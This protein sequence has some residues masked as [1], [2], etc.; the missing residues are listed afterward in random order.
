MIKQN[1]K[2]TYVLD[3]NILMV[4]PKALFGFK[5][6]NVV[7]TGTTLQE[8]DHH[9]NDVGERGFNTRETIR[10]LDDLR[11]KGNLLKG[12]E[13]FSGGRLILEPN[14]I[15]KNLPQ[16][17]SLDVP[18]NRIISSV[19]GMAESNKYDKP[20]ILVTND[21][22][23]R[24]NAS[25]CGVTVQGYR[26]EM[27]EDNEVYKGKREYPI[28]DS[29][30][31]KLYELKKIKASDKANFIENEYVVLKSKKNPQK[32]A[33]ALYREGYLILIRD[34]Y[35]AGYG[36][37]IGRNATQRMF[38]H[39]LMTPPE[40][41]PL[42]LGIGPAGTGKTLLAISCAL[43]QT[44]T[45]SKEKRYDQ[46]LITRANVLTE[47]Y[48]YLPGTLEE[49]INPLLNSFMDNMH[50]IFSGR[51]KDAASANEQIKYLMDSGIVKAEAIGYMRGRSLTHTY[52]IVDEAQNLTVNQA[53]EIV[54]RAG[55]GTKVVFLGD[56]NQ[57]DARYLDKRSNGL[58]FTA[59]KM[60]NDPL[61]AQ[62]VFEEDE[63]QRSPLCVSASKKMSI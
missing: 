27:I 37:I 32:S 35:L 40:I 14:C 8:L 54:T 21:V 56:P 50:T 22:S 31:D 19:I 11:K 3:T 1:A 6:N 43:S 26:N 42:V 28:A 9:K 61:C 13:L 63:A 55:E 58:V 53:L 7:I 17:Y 62:L 2:K 5:E 10:L 36:G 29:K 4:T 51:Q 57:I 46:I 25:V 52:L 48:G 60:K 23:M 39:A 44:Y 12:V 15:S 16:G 24:I 38:M 45:N 20:I 30:I 49:K 34:K 18:D 47:E 41:T 33:V 59:E